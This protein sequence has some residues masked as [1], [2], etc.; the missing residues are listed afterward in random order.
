MSEPDDFNPYQS[1]QVQSIPATEL[2]ILSRISY[3]AA[4]ILQCLTIAIGVPLACWDIET[5]LGSGVILSSF[6]LLCLATALRAKFTPGIIFGASG[7]LMTLVCFVLINANG[8]RPSDAQDPIGG[9]AV[10]YGVTFGILGFWTLFRSVPR[11]PQSSEAS[12][13]EN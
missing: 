10:A 5:I 8:W 6:G 1:P 3:R 12:P 9:L 7:P 11:H 13:W 2:R 4:A